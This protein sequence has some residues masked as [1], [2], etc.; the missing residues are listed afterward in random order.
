[1]VGEGGSLSNK[2]TSRGRGIRNVKHRAVALTAALSLICGGLLIGCSSIT[3]GGTLPPVSAEDIIKQ[4]E[5]SIE[6]MKNNP[7]M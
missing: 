1:L 6:Q 7:N 2:P 5:K 4:A 3:G